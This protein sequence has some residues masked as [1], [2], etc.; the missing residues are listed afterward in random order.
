MDPLQLHCLD[1]GMTVYSVQIVS[2]DVKSMVS[3]PPE[4]DMQL[5]MADAAVMLSCQS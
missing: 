5:S 1:G 2:C 3:L 4:A